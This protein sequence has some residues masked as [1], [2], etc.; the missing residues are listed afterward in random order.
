[1]VK[2]CVEERHHRPVFTVYV[3][4]D[5]PDDDALNAAG[6]DGVAAVVGRR[7]DASDRFDSPDEVYALINELIVARSGRSTSAG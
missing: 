5:V 4:E 1:M 6:E 2:R 3:G 7:R